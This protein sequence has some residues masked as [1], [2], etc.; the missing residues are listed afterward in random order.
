MKI[1][2]KGITLIALVV[3][4][5]VLL[6]LAGVSISMLTGENGIVT[7]AQEAK[8]MTELATVNEAIDLYK[9][10]KTMDGTRV[11]TDLDIA[12]DEEI[13]KI[14][15]VNDTSRRVYVI[16]NFEKLKIDVSIGNGYEDNNLDGLDRIGSITE[17][18]DVVLKDLSDG[19]IYYVKNE[20]IYSLDGSLTVAE[21]LYTKVEGTPGDWETIDNGDGTL[22]IVGYKGSDTEVVIPNY[23][24]GKKVT[25]VRSQGEG[26]IFENNT[27][28]TNESG[29]WTR[30]ANDTIT[31]LIIS[32]GIEE[33]G[34]NAFA[35]CLSITGDLIIPNSVVTIREL[36]FAYC[37]S[38]NGTLTLGNQLETIGRQSFQ[39][40]NVTGDLIIP[41]SVVT[42]FDHAFYDC[43]SLDGRL[44][45]GNRVETIEGYAFSN[46]VKLHGNIEIPESVKTIGERAFRYDTGFDGTLK[47]GSQV[48]SIG[49]EAFRG[50]TG[51]TGNLNI[52]DNV[53]TLGIS[54]FL[55][56]TGFDGT[57]K[58]SENITL[59]P[60]GAFYQ[61][62]GLKGDIVIPDK[63]T[64]IGRQ[65][66]MYDEGFDG[67]LQLGENLAKIGHQAFFQCKNLKGEVILRK[68]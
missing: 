41:D 39:G 32:E 63:V 26:P 65:A 50:C 44:I 68:L 27:T 49:Q 15:G 2:E 9:T 16:K 38:L 29:S 54:A 48:T 42:I 67:T 18:N 58:I 47:I 31:K 4:I 33:I 36:A 55:G 40:V 66:F 62:T 59:I 5:V 21:D 46:C 51:L 25:G 20:T 61:C 37:S 11:Y 53:T 14:L 8:I 56:C 19:K 28:W 57:L 52:P 30:P 13:S 7:R 6:I 24:E 60:E 1:K 10:E 34:A 64:E 23:Y 35:Q 22:T 17:L 45:I 3:T 43:K 12:Q